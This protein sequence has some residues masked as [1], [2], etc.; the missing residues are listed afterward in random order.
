MKTRTNEDAL[1]LFADLLEPAAE[2]FTDKEVVEILQSGE[3]PIK[4]VKIAIKNHKSAVIEMLARI[5]GIEPEDYKV[6]II[7]LPVKLLNLL[8]KPE[9]QD[10]FTLQGQEIDV[11]SSGSATENTKDGVK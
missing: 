11:G 8:N 10:L 9:L 3:K 1:E 6:N 5:D 4:A 2:I 7:S